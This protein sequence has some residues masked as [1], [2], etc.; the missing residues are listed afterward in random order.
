MAKQP[1]SF[2][3]EKNQK[4]AI[5]ALS[6]DVWSVCEDLRQDPATDDEVLALFAAAIRRSKSRADVARLFAEAQRVTSL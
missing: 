1:E 3:E 4:L 6:R 5:R 2:D